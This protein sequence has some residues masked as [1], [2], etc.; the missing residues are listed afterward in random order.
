[1]KQDLKHTST[2]TETLLQQCK[3]TI[4]TRRREKGRREGGKLIQHAQ[5]CFSNI[6]IVLLKHT[7]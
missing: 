4:A 7:F 2:P 3:T 5:I 6:Q 1:M